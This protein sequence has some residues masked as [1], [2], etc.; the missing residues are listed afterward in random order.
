MLGWKHVDA[1]LLHIHLFIEVCNYGLMTDTDRFVCLNVSSDYFILDVHLLSYSFRLMSLS[2]S[3]MLLFH[4]LL[5]V[6]LS[7]SSQS[8][9]I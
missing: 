9:W 3:L 7:R 4:F 8:V 5:I 1:Y 6:K 2:I